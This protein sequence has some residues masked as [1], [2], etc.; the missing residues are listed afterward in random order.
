MNNPTK[1]HMDL[2]QLLKTKVL[3]VEFTKQNGETRKMLCTTSPV[4]IPPA[5]TPKGTLVNLNE[6]TLRVF[7]IES[8]GWRSFKLASVK[9][10]NLEETA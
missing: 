6:E 8:Q 1:T 5:H 9:N 4:H 3:R 2:K 7:D 10:F